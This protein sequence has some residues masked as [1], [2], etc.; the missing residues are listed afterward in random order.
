MHLELWQWLC[1]AAAAL[2]VGVSKT[3]IPGA[4]IPV[5]SASAVAFRGTQVCAL[6]APDAGFRRLFRGGVVPATRA[7]GQTGEAASMG[8]RRDGFGCNRLVGYRLDEW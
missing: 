4:G 3:V 1:G 5:V 2:L 8:G 7:V 6:R